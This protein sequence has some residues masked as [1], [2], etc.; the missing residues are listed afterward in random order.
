MDKLISSRLKEIEEELFEL[1]SDRSNVGNEKVINFI[2]VEVTK[3]E[4][5]KSK[6]EEK[7]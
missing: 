6:L 1:E 4:E 3:L 5:E 7:L 2:E